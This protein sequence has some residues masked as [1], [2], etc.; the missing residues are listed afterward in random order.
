ML[1]SKGEVACAKWMMQMSN[2]LC[3]KSVVMTAG[4]QLTFNGNILHY[5][6]EC[7]VQHRLVDEGL[8]GYKR[9]RVPLLMKAHV[10]KLWAWAEAHA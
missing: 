3:K 4:Q 5:L 10:R 2:L 8:K 7:T 9:W 6:S 1:T